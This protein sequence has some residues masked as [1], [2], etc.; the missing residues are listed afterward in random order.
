MS[1][2]FFTVFT[3]ITLFVAFPLAA[4]D[5][6]F[7]GFI[8]ILSPLGTFFVFTF[9]TLLFAASFA[10]TLVMLGIMTPGLTQLDPVDL[11]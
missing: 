1:Y 5:F 3:F 7:S 6:P 8:C 11:Y 2:F 4:I 9:L 10:L